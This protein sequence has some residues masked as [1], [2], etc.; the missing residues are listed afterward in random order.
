MRRSTLILVVAI[1]VLGGILGTGI[2]WYW[3]HSPRYALQQMVLALKTKDMPKL[4]NYLDTKAIF[5]NILEAASKDEEKDGPG[6]ELN[7]LSRQFGKQFARQ[8]LPKLFDVL[9]KQ[10]RAAI[11]TYLDS[12]DN[13]Q[14]LALGAA[15]TTARIDVEGE[16][17]QVTMH[18]PKTGRPLRLQMQYFAQDRTWRL[19]AVNYQDLKAFVG[20][21]FL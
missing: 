7:R 11:E 19:V 4:F 8:L 14:I 5:N 6:D 18:D 9:E 3:Q 17:A 1:I 15:V 21:K 2:F 16:Q 12:L 13:T 10:I 20:H